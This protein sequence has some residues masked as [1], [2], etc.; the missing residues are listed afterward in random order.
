MI[1]YT[2][3]MLEE[4]IA[5]S[6][7]FAAV[8]RYFKVSPHG[9]IRGHLKTRADKYGIDYRHFADPKKF[10]HPITTKKTAVDILVLKPVGSNRTHAVFLRRALLEV[11]VKVE[12]SLCDLGPVWNNKPLQLEVDHLDG[13][14]LNNCKENIRFICPN[15]HTQTGNYKSKN[16]K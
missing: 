12:C 15:C 11:G 6:K 8:A 16:R 2:K 1:K 7:S 9:G 5:V 4:A 13:N 3:K 10:S 14:Y